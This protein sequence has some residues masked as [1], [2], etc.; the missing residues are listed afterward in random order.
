MKTSLY[1]PHYDKLRSWMKQKR[2]ESGLSLRSVAEKMGR[3]HSVVGKMEQDR[4][5]IEMLEFIE[6]CHVIGA[7][8]HEGLELVMKSIYTKIWYC[9]QSGVLSLNCYTPDK[10]MVIMFHQVTG[11]FVINASSNWVLVLLRK[12]GFSESVRVKY[13]CPD[14]SGWCILCPGQ[15]SII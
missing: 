1:S 7:D 11:Q 4:R 3:H 13:K 12:I 6:Y 5:K 8:P 15:L 2:E 9:L 14:N 10:R